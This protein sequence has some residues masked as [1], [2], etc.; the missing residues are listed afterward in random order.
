VDIYLPICGEPIEL[1]RNTWTAVLGLIEDY[2]GQREAYVLDDG[3][4]SE[5]R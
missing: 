4:S 1:L 3:P 2:P 5:A